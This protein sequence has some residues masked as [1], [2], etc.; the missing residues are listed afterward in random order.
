MRARAAG[1]SPEEAVA[2]LGGPA[3]R[4]HARGRFLKR[5]LDR[6]R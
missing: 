1:R 4:W 5:L 3:A 6:V 2:A